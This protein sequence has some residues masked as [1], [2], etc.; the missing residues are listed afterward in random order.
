MIETVPSSSTTTTTPL[1][2]SSVALIVPAATVISLPLTVPLLTFKVS[3]AV[4]FAVSITSISFSFTVYLV[5]SSATRLI[6]PVAPVIAIPSPSNVLVAKSI[7]PS[8]SA[9]A[10]TVSVPAFKVIDFASVIEPVSGTAVASVIVPPGSA[11]TTVNV[12]LSTTSIAIL[13]DKLET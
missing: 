6:S 4:T 12:A 5:D 8:S 9:P 3:P 11:V 2:S 1:S 7:V 10:L 13:L